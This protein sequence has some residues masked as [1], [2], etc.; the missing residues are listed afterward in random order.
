MNDLTAAMGINRPSLYAAFGCKEALFQEA[1][2]LYDATAGAPAARALEEAP[3][4]REAVERVLRVN[5]S[6]GAAPGTAPGCMIV[7]AATVGSP[8]TEEVRALLSRRRSEGQIGLR[9]RLQR[10]MAEGDLPQGADI[11]GIAMFYTAVLQGLT[12]QARDGAAA[13]ALHRVVD[14]AMAAWDVLVRPSTDEQL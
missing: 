12:I 10:A 4:A 7:L 3:T 11:D 9:N 2:T 6:Y 5:A 14:K 8:E 13:E 1:V